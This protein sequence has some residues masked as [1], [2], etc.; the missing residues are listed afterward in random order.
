MITGKLKNPVEKE[1]VLFD[2]M[3]GSVRLTQF[4]WCQRFL[5]VTY[6][7]VSLTQ[8]HTESC[9]VNKCLAVL[10]IKKIICVYKIRLMSTQKHHS[11]PNI[12]V[13]YS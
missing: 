4:I 8:P 10:R 1:K 11:H 7:Y 9:S 12:K 2:R 3:V 13:S 5:L 6:S